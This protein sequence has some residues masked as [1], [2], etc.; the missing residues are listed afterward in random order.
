MFVLTID[1]QKS[2]TRGDL[3]PEL[4]AHLAPL[5]ERAGGARLPFERTVGDEVQGVVASPETALAV[6][7]GV[8]RIGGWRIGLGAGPVDEPL[9]A[10]SRE[11][12]GPAFVRARAAIDRAK[13]RTTGV[14]VAVEGGAGVP[15]AEAVL[16]L[17]GAVVERRTDQGWEVVDLLTDGTPG[18]AGRVRT[19]KE[20]ARILGISEQAVSQRVQNALWAEELAAWPLAARLLGEADQ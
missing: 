12:S 2:T 11:A 19:Q 6:V 8:L 17:L 3:V 20:I 18:G 1:Q 4:L 15:D 9:P 7:L 14:P 13:P 5:T 10:H 16:R